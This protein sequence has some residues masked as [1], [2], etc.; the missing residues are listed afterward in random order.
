MT[1]AKEN[2]FRSAFSV[3]LR[4]LRAE[5]ALTIEKVSKGA[6]VSARSYCF[7]EAGAMP[8]GSSLVKLAA[9]YGMTPGELL[10]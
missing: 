1:V 3:R 6:G 9:F 2:K 7:W 5:K 8:N 10:K 4:Q